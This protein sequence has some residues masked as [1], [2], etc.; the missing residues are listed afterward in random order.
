MGCFSLAR[1]VDGALGGTTSR[2]H[3]T[4]AVSRRNLKCHIVDLRNTPF[5]VQ[6]GRFVSWVWGTTLPRVIGICDA[7]GY[8]FREACRS[9]S[10]RIFDVE[11]GQRERFDGRGRHIVIPPTPRAASDDDFSQEQTAMKRVLLIG[12]KPEVVDFSDP[13]LPKGLTA[14][15]VASGIEASLSDMKSRGWETD[16]CS[17]LMDDTMEAIIA[18]SLMEHWDCIVIGAG[19]RLPFK[20]LKLFERVLNAVHRG[21]PQTPIAFNT[22]PNDTGDAAARWLGP[23]GT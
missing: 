20:G 8:A 6:I 10:E 15:I 14:E 4:R 21:A 19:V 9:G 11:G 23:V 5:V 7:G 18:S 17:L 12:F 16:L 2:P 1:S 13:D 22:S 3:G